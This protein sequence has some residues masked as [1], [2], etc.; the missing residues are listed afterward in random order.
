[1]EANGGLYEGVRVGLVSVITTVQNIGLTTNYF[2]YIE[3]LFGKDKK[4]NK[5]VSGV[6]GKEGTVF[7][8][9]GGME[10]SKAISFSRRGETK[11]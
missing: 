1:M 9:V 2:F 7:G 5:A 4:V 6:D 10:D 11:A 3:I 8:T